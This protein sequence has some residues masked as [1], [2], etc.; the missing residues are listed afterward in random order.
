MLNVGYS[1]CLL[2]TAAI[3]GKIYRE[4]KKYQAK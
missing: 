4:N 1:N 3:L 2:D